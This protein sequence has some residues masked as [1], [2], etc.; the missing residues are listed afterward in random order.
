MFEVLNFCHLDP[1][2]L[3]ITDFEDGFLAKN[4]D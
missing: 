3:L 1:L 2:A 4:I